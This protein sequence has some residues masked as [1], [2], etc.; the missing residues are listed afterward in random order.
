MLTVII[1][2]VIF[3]MFLFFIDTAN[4]QSQISTQGGMIKKYNVLTEHFLGGHRDSKILKKTA[5]S[6]LI[7]VSNAGGT[8]LF[9]LIQ[10]YGNVT[11][12]WKLESPV[13]GRHKLEWTFPEH[14][15]QHKMLKKIENDMF[16]YYGKLV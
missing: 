13:F 7:G 14:M 16:E 2:G 8:T 9:R 5:D 10:T 11:I 15:S 1:I 4:Q 12:N 6:L 3:I